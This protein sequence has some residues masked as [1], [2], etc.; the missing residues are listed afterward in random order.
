MKGYLKILLC[1]MAFI[2][3]SSCANL[4]SERLKV[5]SDIGPFKIAK[6]DLGDIHTA[7]Y[8]L[9]SIMSKTSRILDQYGILYDPQKHQ[10]YL[11]LELIIYA[12]YP[13]FARHENMSSYDFLETKVT[14]KDP[15]G[16]IIKEGTVST[17]NAFRETLADFTEN[18]HAK[19]I[20]RFLI[21]K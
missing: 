4:D 5:P 20:L 1:L 18:Q 21:S 9:N 14:V 15:D 6:V 12:I 11:T 7:P 3:V 17:V 10:K 8:L 16:K 13:A 19:E 2:F